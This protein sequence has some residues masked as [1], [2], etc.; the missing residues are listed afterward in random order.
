MNLIIVIIAKYLVFAMIVAAG[1]YWLTLPKKQKIETVIFACIASII[2]IVL[3]RVGSS[4]FYDTRPF[5]ANHVAPLFAH[6]NDNGFPSDHT[7]IAALIAATIITVSKK[8]GT[9]L[10]VCAILIGAS[11]VLAHVHSP[12]DILGSLGMVAIGGALAYWVAPMIAVKLLKL[13]RELV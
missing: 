3:A 2:A 1:I 12:I 13:S 9:T 11:R 5:V 6:G 8:W 4:L 10:L 7:L